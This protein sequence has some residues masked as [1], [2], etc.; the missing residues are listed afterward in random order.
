VEASFS[1]GR[2]LHDEERG[3]SRVLAFLPC[4]VRPFPFKGRAK[5]SRISEVKVKGRIFVEVFQKGPHNGGGGRP[6]AHK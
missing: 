6:L 5:C 1:P 2:A 4:L 3:L